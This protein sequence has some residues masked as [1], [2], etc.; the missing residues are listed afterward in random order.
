MVKASVVACA[1]KSRLYLLMGTWIQRV[2]NLNCY[3]E[4][5][6]VY[7]AVR[8][9]QEANGAYLDGSCVCLIRSTLLKF[10]LLRHRLTSIWY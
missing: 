9:V 3:C 5:L 6:A 7:L 10:I 2:K 8:K 1:A 4:H